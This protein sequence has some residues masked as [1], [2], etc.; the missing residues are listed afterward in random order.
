MIKNMK[1]MFQTMVYRWSLKIARK[2]MKKSL[3]SDFQVV[4]GYETEGSLF[5]CFM[6]T[7]TWLKTVI[8]GC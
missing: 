2:G 4:L 8:P 6:S 1:F 5:S 7:E 3:D